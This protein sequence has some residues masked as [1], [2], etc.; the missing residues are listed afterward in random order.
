MVIFL[1]WTLC[2]RGKSHQRPMNK[3]VDGIQSQ[4]GR[5][6]EEKKV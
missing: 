5:F 2:A 1:S 3:K 6:V 4:P